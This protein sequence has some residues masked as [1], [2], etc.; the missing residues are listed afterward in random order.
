MDWNGIYV[1]HLLNLVE[2]LF[3]TQNDHFQGRPPKFLIFAPANDGSLRNTK[4]FLASY[5]C[6]ELGHRN[7]H[8]YKF[9]L[10]GSFDS[11]SSLSNILSVL[12]DGAL[13]N[14]RSSSQSSLNIALD[15]HFFR[16]RMNIFQF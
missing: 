4:F 11:L 12:N 7:S 14:Y 5:Y 6:K 13:N 16:L 9:K 3:H 10:S 2:Q 8:C 1:L 15:K